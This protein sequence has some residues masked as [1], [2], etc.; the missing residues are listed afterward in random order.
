[1]STIDQKLVKAFENANGARVAAGTV[2]DQS[3]AEHDAAA[4]VVAGAEPTPL[5]SPAVA[6]ADDTRSKIGLLN[7]QA[8]GIDS[9]EQPSAVHSQ[10]GLSVAVEEKWQPALEVDHFAWPPIVETVLDQAGKMLGQLSERLTQAARNRTQ[11]IAVVGDRPQSGATTMTLSLARLFAANQLSVA[12][13]DLDDS[14]PQLAQALGVRPMISWLA[15]LDEGV[16]LEEVLI[17]SVKDQVTL[18]PLCQPSDTAINVNGASLAQQFWLPLSNHF[19]VIL[20]DCGT[21]GRNDRL[22]NV[23]STAGVSELILVADNRCDVG[24]VAEI[25]RPL[26]EQVSP[27]HWSVIRNFSA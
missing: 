5:E 24:T 11:L 22:A 9:E 27:V 20:A 16:A 8:A 25:A 21:A 26:L 1:M 6:V 19:D 13:V 18:S 4:E 15:M 14:N 2:V 10:S 3:P 17:E 12:L 23:L 7:R